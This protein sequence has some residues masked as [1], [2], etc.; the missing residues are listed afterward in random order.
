LKADEILQEFAAKKLDEPIHNVSIKQGERITEAASG[1]LTVT[2]DGSPRLEIFFGAQPTNQGS[3]LQPGVVIPDDAYTTVTA[4]TVRGLKLTGN[5]LFPKQTQR[6]MPGSSRMVFLPKQVV[7]VSQTARSEKSGL[8]GI[9]TA[10]PEDVFNSDYLVNDDCPM[11]GGAVHQMWLRLEF[12]QVLLGLRKDESKTS[13][14]RLWSKATGDPG[15]EKLGKGFLRALSFLLGRRLHWQAYCYSIGDEERITL[16]RQIK[17]TK[18]HFPPLPELR[19]RE[20]MDE[21]SELLQQATFFFQ[22]P[23]NEPVLTALQVCWDAADNFFVTRG[24]LL[25]AALEGLADYLVDESPRSVVFSSEKEAFAKLKELALKVLGRDEQLSKDAL[26]K[27][28]TKGI[29]S[30]RFLTG[31]DKIRK[32][33]ELLGVKTAEVEIAAWKNLRRAPAH[34]DFDF[35]FTDQSKLQLAVNQTATV[36]N[37]LNKFVLALIGYK[38]PFRDYAATG[39]STRNFPS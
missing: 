14:L 15:L 30:F 19:S 6:H 28:I 27:R 33:A 9:I 34:G 21:Q 2:D 1:R 22:D 23:A 35:D 13:W 18:R 20:L 26:L 25:C 37:I 36:A 5:W 16:R 24:L 10:F 29:S 7:L 4:D 31:A 3:G 12:D 17:V 39:Y 11:F 38:G 8:E 32:A